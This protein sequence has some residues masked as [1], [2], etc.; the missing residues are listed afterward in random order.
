MKAFELMIVTAMAAVAAPIVGASAAQAAPLTQYNITLDGYC[1]G[2][3]LNLPSVGLPGHGV[4]GGRRQDRLRER[5][6]LLYGQAQQ[7]R[8]VWRQE[9]LRAHDGPT[10]STHIVVNR[11]HTWVYYGLSGN[12]IYVSNSGAPGPPARRSPPRASPP[13]RRE[14]A[15]PSPFMSTGRRTS[16]S[17]RLLRWHAPRQPLGGPRDE[18]YRGWQRHRLR[19]GR[20]DGL[21]EHVSAA[22]R[23][24]TRSASSPAGPRGSSTS[25]SRNHT[26]PSST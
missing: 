6:D 2:L 17:T 4:R 25:S 10:Y 23:A 24:R 19:D 7:A 18:G 26:G 12:L 13:S 3:S 14:P 20:P 1:D 22:R 11:N 9:G 15:W 8:G 16:L 21:Q 5:W